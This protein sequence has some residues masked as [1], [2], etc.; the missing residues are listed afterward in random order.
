VNDP[1][2]ERCP[3]CTDTGGAHEGEAPTLAADRGRGRDRPVVTGAPSLVGTT[4]S[5]PNRNNAVTLNFIADCQNCD[6]RVG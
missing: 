1:T 6:E 3:E 4:V 2:G 5:D